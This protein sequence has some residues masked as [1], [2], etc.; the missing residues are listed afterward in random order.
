MSKTTQKFLSVFL[1]I[2][3]VVWL[4]GGVVVMPAKAAT[5]EELQAQIQ[6]LLNQ[7][8]QLQSQ[9]AALQGGSQQQESVSGYHFTKFLYKGVKDPEVSDLQ[10][11][12]KSDSSVY[13][14]GLVTGYFGPLTEAAVK[15]FQIKYGIVASEDAYGA[16]YVGP[17]TRAKLNELYGGTS[18]PSEEQPSQPSEEQPSE[19][20]GQQPATETG[21]TVSLASDSPA[22]GTIIADSTDDD[23]AQALASV[24]KLTF[25]AGSDAVK[26]KTLKIKRGGISTDS[27]I[28]NAYLMDGN[29]V[30][31]E[32]N[33]ISDKVMTFTSSDKLFEVPA[34]SS[35]SIVIA[36]DLTNGTSSGKTITLS[37]ESASDVTTDGAEVSGT[38]PITSNV[39][40]TASVSDLGKLDVEH[41]TSLSTVDAGSTGIELWKFKLSGS[42]QKI[43]VSKIKLTAIGTISYDAFNN[44]ELRVDGVKVAGGEGTMLDSDKTVTF[45]LSDSP[46]EIGLGQTK[47]VSLVGDVIKG[48]DRTF[49]FRITSRHDIVAKDLGYNVYVKPNQSDVWSIV[50]A[51]TETSINQGSLTVDKA[52]D[53]PSGNLA[54]GATNVL[55]AKFYYKA[56]GE[57]IK[58]SSVKVKVAKV[59]GTATSTSNLKVMVD[60]VQIG[61]TQSTA[62]IGTSY[63]F[64]PGNSFIVPAGETK[65]LYVYAD[66]N[67]S[68]IATGA[69]IK[70]TLEAGSDNAL[71]MSTGTTFDAP[72]SDKD[73]NTLTVVQSTLSTSKNS[74]VADMTLIKGS[75]DVVIGS[76]LITAPSSEAVKINSISVMASSS[77]NGLGKAFDAL[78]LYYNGSQVGQTINS[79]STSASDYSTFSLSSP[80]EVSAGQSVKVD[81]K[82]NVLTNAT[83]ADNDAVKIKSV[84]A[85]GVVTNSTVQDTTG[86][87]G[88][89]ITV[90]TAGTL[91]V[92][93]SASPTN[94]YSQYFVAG[95]TDQTLGAWKFSANN[96]EDIVVTRV[97]VFATSSAIGNIQNVKLYVDGAQVD[98]TAPAL[99]SQTGTYNGYVLFEDSNGLF[100]VPKNSY[101]TL[102][103]KADI[104]GKDNASFDDDGA[105]MKLALNMPTSIGSTSDISAKGALSGQYVSVASGNSGYK[106]ANE[107]KI[108]KTKPTFALVSLSNT[109]ISGASSLSQGIIKF[110]ISAHSNNDVVFSSGTHNIRFTIS[111]NK[112]SITGTGRTFSLYD[113]ASGQKVASDV[114]VTPNSGVVIDFDQFSGANNELVIPAGG[115]KTLLVTGD[116][117]DYTGQYD[118]FSLSIE[119]TSGDLSWSDGSSASAAIEDDNYSGLGLPLS[120][121][122]LEQ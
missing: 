27:D 22:A 45:D 111:S 72:G 86:A 87:K 51:T 30:I 21:L 112:S 40:S 116:L 65:Y 84:S 43:E 60:G 78:K 79:P 17:K 29:D 98:S 118:H 68:G 110:T 106:V 47:Y 101:K 76:W 91:T 58:I 73:S 6:T 57:D 96:T 97:K 104:T 85:T 94:P 8:A 81:L 56:V 115:S 66:L 35:K 121:Q 100:T 20:E 102:V 3:T 77:S 5:V 55:L 24:L 53:S 89:G 2:A 15:R 69:Q 59:S 10:T 71:R 74:S 64:N 13:P 63:S 26:V 67:S 122:T 33:S 48:S 50:Y 93:V 38:F 31:A 7:I 46:V 1:S 109:K 37:L 92:A 44:L 11:V 119:N 114:S 25:Q 32:M 113:V 19:E 49:Y 82:A 120:G 117:S 62:T 23:G 75:Q 70:V 4:V 88:Q 34:N 12:L 52:T 108:V 95:D 107:H 42:D 83:W 39:M 103:V 18:A 9:L 54:L 14:E 105:S 28:S 61:T 99:V 36:I 90:T 41:S 80:I 16:G